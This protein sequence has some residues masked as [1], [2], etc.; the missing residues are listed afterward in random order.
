MLVVEM[1]LENIPG[2]G[3][4][5]QIVHVGFPGFRSYVPPKFKSGPLTQKVIPRSTL[6]SELEPPQ[7][8]TQTEAGRPQ[9]SLNA[10]GLTLAPE[11]GEKEGNNRKRSKLLLRCQRESVPVAEGR[12]LQP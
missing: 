9:R 2:D 7:T 5:F 10:K 8:D 12:C 4:F 3:C 6:F 11:C 1:V